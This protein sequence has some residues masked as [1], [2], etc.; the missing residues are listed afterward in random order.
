[1][2]AATRDAV[3]TTVRNRNPLT[4]GPEWSEAGWRGPVAFFIFHLHLNG[5]NDAAAAMAFLFFIPIQS[6]RYPPG[7]SNP[8]E[9]IPNDGASAPCRALDQSTHLH[10]QTHARSQSMRGGS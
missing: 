10:I 4:A 1:M 5:S 9:R 8:R 7:G 6:M 2:A 3:K